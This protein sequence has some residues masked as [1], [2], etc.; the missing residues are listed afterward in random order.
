MVTD[1]AYGHIVNNVDTTTEEVSHTEVNT[2][3]EVR[4]YFSDIPVLIQVARCESRFRH[5]LA[6]GSVL[7]GTVD[8]RDTGVMQINSFYHGKT[9]RDMG[10]DLNKLHDNM[11]YARYLYK[12]QG[13]AP[14]RASSSCW[15]VTLAS[16]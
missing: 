8:P 1:T 14:W 16:L 3:A 7:K 9:A 5:T 4:K 6:D 11:V 15:G 12:T 13:T 10:L 2:E